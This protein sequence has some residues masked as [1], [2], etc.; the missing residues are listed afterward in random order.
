MLGG[1]A[2]FRAGGMSS[3]PASAEVATAGPAGFWRHDPLVGLPCR[4]TVGNKD[5]E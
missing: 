1:G 3:S 2:P 4:K 5:R